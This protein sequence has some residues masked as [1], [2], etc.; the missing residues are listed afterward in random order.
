P[1]RRGDRP[2]PAR[3]R[4]GGAWDARRGRLPAS[5][6]RRR[7]ALMDYGQPL[8]FGTFI[9]PDA[10]DPARTVDLAVLS[11]DL[12]YDVVTFQDHPYQPR[13]LDTW[14][15]LSWVAGRTSTIHLAAD[16]LNVPMRPPA[17]LA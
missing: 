14:T 13:F 1:V 9:T 6:H 4:R 17:V 7:P 3:G 11:E 2:R 5:A 12:G 8:T 10:A 15:L 16:V